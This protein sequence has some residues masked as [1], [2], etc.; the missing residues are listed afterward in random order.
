M[1]LCC[2][3]VCIESASLCLYVFLF[4]VCA[5]YDRSEHV[6]RERPIVGCRFNTHT[7][8]MKRLI[9]FSQGLTMAERYNH[10]LS[11]TQTRIMLHLFM[12]DIY[13]LIWWREHGWVYSFFWVLN[14]VQIGIRQELVIIRKMCKRERVRVSDKE[15]ERERERDTAIELYSKFIMYI[16][17]WIVI[18]CGFVNV[19]FHSSL[20]C[21]LK[22]LN[23]LYNFFYWQLSHSNYFR[24][25]QEIAATITYYKSAND[26]GH[27]DEVWRKTW[28]AAIELVVKKIRENLY[29]LKII[30]K[31]RLATAYFIRNWY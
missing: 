2:V 9:F 3:R 22:F 30:L 20:E 21:E 17:Y 28:L 31:R 16:F 11:T 8:D 29:I 13:L 1:F 23:V 19:I 27:N 24:I 7:Y 12:S 5:L 15:G 18:Q 25:E 6:A 4:H 26:S 14:S 10:L